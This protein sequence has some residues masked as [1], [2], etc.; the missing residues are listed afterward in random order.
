MSA[1]LQE[2]SA[3]WTDGKVRVRGSVETS[4]G[5][6]ELTLEED[7]PGA[8]GEFD[9]TLRL[10]LITNPPYSGTTVMTTMTF[11]QSFGA[12]DG[13]HT[14]QLALQGLTTADGADHI[15]VPIE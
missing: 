10:K 7:N 15:T 13:D 1:V 12:N 14:L 5:G 4:S 8:A 3:A 9:E 2:V 11:D 6:W